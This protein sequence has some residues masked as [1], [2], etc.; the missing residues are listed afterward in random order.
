VAND[1]GD[2]RAENIARCVS[3][4]LDDVRGLLRP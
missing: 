3:V 1:I 2:T 4:P